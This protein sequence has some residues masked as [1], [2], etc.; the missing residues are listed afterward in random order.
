MASP[1]PKDWPNLK[2]FGV[3]SANDGQDFKSG[4]LAEFMKHNFHRELAKR[5]DFYLDTI[6]K[7]TNGT[8]KACKAAFNL[9]REQSDIKTETFDRMIMKK[10]DLSDRGLSTMM[11]IMIDKDLHVAGCG[12]FSALISS[13]RGEIIQLIRAE[14][15]RDSCGIHLN[16][17]SSMLLDMGVSLSS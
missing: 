7:S 11:I 15:Q 12:S 2:F 1:N 8:F 6:E 10:Q 13:Q 9:L 5:R 3:Y 17:D 16:N 4:E 14:S